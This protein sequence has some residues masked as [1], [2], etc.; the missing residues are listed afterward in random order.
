MYSIAGKPLAEPGNG[1]A[2]VFTAISNPVCALNARREENNATR[3]L[4]NTAKIMAENPV[5]L[6]LKELQA[7]EKSAGQG[8]DADGS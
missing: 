5:M 7:L 3:S 2:S 4:L 1:M 6:R 8:P